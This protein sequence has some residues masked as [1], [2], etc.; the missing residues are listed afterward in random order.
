MELVL[1]ALLVHKEFK[2]LLVLS[3]LLALKEMLVPKV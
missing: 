2:V 1:Q 3:V